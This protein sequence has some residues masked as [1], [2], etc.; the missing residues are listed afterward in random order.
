M[1]ALL[2]LSGFSPEVCAWIAAASLLAFVVRGVS[3]FGSAMLGIGALSLVLPPAQVVPAFLLLE[4]LT[5]AHLLPGLWRQVDWR[6]LPWVLGAA[7]AA[8]PLGLALL[9]RVDAG[10]MRL[11]VSA[12]LLGIALAM[13]SGLAARLASP[14]PPGRAAALAAGAV[15]GLLNGAVGISGPPVI[16]F[17]FSR[18]AAAVGRA[19][20]IAY[21]LVSDAAALAMAAAGGLLDG[22]AARLVLVALPFALAGIWLGQRWY[23]RLDEARLRRL[24]WALLAA[25]GALG[26]VK[27]AATAWG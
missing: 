23:A 22:F 4:V 9:A 7:V 26:L 21:F 5:T 24:V 15:S 18:Y 1:D 10:A 8:T 25:L 3:G 6:S 19:T 2:R 11:G 16:V 13:L 12:T 17:Y 14:Q 20:L 27:Q